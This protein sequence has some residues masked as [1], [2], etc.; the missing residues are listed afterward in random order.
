MK[1][2]ILII[3]ISLLMASCIGINKATERFISVCKT[4]NDT[5][6]VDYIDSSHGIVSIEREIKNDTLFLKV[7]VGLFRPHNIFQ[8]KLDQVI[9]FVN[10]GTKTYIFD[11]M[12]ICPKIYTGAEGIEY[13]KSQRKTD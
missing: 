5:I 11:E 1:S 8:I 13:L 9:R 6:H 12:H 2:I 7:Y 10:T 4:S 3:L